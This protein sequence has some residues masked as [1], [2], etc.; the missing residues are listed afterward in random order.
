VV[1]G[2]VA[3]TLRAS[4]LGFLLLVPL[5]LWVH[6]GLGLFFE[7]QHDTL[8]RFLDLRRQNRWDLLLA[9]FL[10]TAVW[11]PIAEELAFRV[12]IQGFVEQFLRHRH[13]LL[14]WLLGPLQAG[15]AGLLGLTAAAQ[16]A[17][18]EPSG[19]ADRP[20]FTSALFWAPIVV[21][22][23]LFALAHFDQGAAPIPLYLLAV[24][25]GF[26]YKTTGNVLLCILIHAYL[27]ALTLIQSLWLGTS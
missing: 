16:L 4:V 21:S 11:T 9:V 26:L 22:S 1:E 3:V 24:G 18:R 5:V 13:N 14:R 12:I 19:R 10:A 7:Y 25:L 27:N 23:L 8:D 2:K 20:G 6:A 17:N 15:P